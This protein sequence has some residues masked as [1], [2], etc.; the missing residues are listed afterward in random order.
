MITIKKTPDK[1]EL[2]TAQ[3]VRIICEAIERETGRVVDDKTVKLGGPSAAACELLPDSR[4]V[5]R[6]A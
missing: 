3:L 4:P 6:D 5:C 2:T 1:I